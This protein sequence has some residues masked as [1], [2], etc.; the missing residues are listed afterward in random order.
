[1]CRPT[2][3]G[4]SGG[5]E[6]APEALRALGLAG[7]GRRARPRRLDV[8]IRGDDRDPESGII[9]APDVLATTLDRSAP[10]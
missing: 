6:F 3:S 7:G 2:P 5:T 4:R 10:R 9:A 8:R 1:M